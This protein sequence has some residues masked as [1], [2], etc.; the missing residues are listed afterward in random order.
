MVPGYYPYWSDE[1]T[2]KNRWRLNSRTPTLRV[3]GGRRGMRPAQ[4]KWKE[5]LKVANKHRYLLSQAYINNNVY[6][7]KLASPAE[8]YK[9]IRGGVICL[10]VPNTSSTPTWISYRHI[11]YTQEPICQPCTLMA[12]NYQLCFF[13]LTFRE[14]YFGAKMWFLK[15]R[16]R[17]FGVS[18]STSKQCTYILTRCPL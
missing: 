13:F 6:S 5:V 18:I 17:H 12:T 8:M 15:K 3:H 7:A 1:N 9:S 4:T 16:S 2:Q 11:H 14:V 10:S